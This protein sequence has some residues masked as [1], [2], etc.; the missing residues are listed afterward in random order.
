MPVLATMMDSTMFKPDEHH[1]VCTINEQL[2]EK[3][4]VYDLSSINYWLKT[5]GAGHVIIFFIIFP[6]LNYDIVTYI[7]ILT[8]M[9]ELLFLTFW[10]VISSGSF[11]L[12]L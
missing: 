10:E 11:L 12:T 3:K 9:Q 8:K 1:S 5:W 6:G 2:L 7:M 4:I